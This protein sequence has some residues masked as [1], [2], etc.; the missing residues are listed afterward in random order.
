MDSY[1]LFVMDDNILSYSTITDE[2][3]IY[4]K[5]SRVTLLLS[6]LQVTNDWI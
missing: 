3:K 4:T 5:K 2:Q 6:P 1:F